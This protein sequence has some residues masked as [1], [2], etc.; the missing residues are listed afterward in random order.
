MSRRP[1][2]GILKMMERTGVIVAVDEEGA[3]VRLNGDSQKAGAERGG[4]TRLDLVVRAG[5]PL[6]ARAGDRVRVR[7]P[8]PGRKRGLLLAV[9][10][11]A[12]LAGAVLGRLVAMIR[13]VSDALRSLGGDFLGPVLA[14][15]H[16][17]AMVFGL[18]ALLFSAA[19]LK[20]VVERG[21]LDKNWR[22][23]VIE[24]LEVD[25]DKSVSA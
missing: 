17:L 20:A 24:V 6:A 11:F 5:N 8:E 7:W 1:D 15:G 22:A 25:G 19:A 3:E 2:Y 14:S 10:L 21:G 23:E 4:G 18:L 16:N 9:P 12:V 13:P